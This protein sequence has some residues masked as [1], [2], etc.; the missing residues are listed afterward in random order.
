MSRKCSRTNGPFQGLQ[1]RVQLVREGSQS[2]SKPIRCPEDVVALVQEIRMW[3]RE[4]F[5]TLA[6]DV[7]NQVLGIE[8]T[9]IGSLSSTPVCPREVF[10]A[11]LLTNAD[12]LI[13]V[14]LHPSGCPEPSSEDKMITQV[15]A[16]GA[17][18]LGLK[19][20]DHIIVTRDKYFSFAEHGLV[21]SGAR[22]CD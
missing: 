19:V 1:V 14:H 15:L 12:G 11:V 8:V 20:L 18:L 22:Q 6:L 3:D 5:L 21:Q 17:E 7:R 2:Y 10:K 4:V 16:K 13:F 9:A